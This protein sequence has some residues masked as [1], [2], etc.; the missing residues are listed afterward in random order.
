MDTDTNPYVMPPRDGRKGGKRG[1][2]ANAVVRLYEDGTPV[3]VMNPDGEPVPPKPALIQ[4]QENLLT[5]FRQYE[6]DIMM[7]G[8]LKRKVNDLDVELDPDFDYDVDKGYGFMLLKDYKGAVEKMI[9]D[10]P[11]AYRAEA[12][13]TV[14]NSITRAMGVRPLWLVASMQAGVLAWP[15]FPKLK[16]MMLLCLMRGVQFSCRQAENGQYDSD[17]TWPREV[18]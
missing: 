7:D 5:K 9:D 16:V 10:I 2:K 1:Q 13:C 11:D 12:V 15:P 3:P 14:Q 8:D 18:D 17:E 6:H 4:Y